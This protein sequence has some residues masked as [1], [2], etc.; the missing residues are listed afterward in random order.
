MRAMRWGIAP[1]GAPY[2]PAFPYVAYSGLTRRD[3]ADMWSYLSAL[4]GVERPNRPHE[5]AFPFG[6]RPL[7]MGWQFLFFAPRHWRAEAGRS[8]R[9]NRGAYL[10]RHL[11]HCAECHTG[12]NPLGALASGMDYAG[13]KG[14]ADEGTVPN[15]TPHETGIAGWSESDIVWLLKTG[16]TPEG[17]DVQ[18]SMAALVRHGSSHLGDDDLGAVAEYVLSLPPIDN[19]VRGEPAETAAQGADED[20][21]YDFQ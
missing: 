16:F 17:D 13:H 6:F 7:V 3:L 11:L 15:I 12:R 8:E 10:S 2:Y 20:Y 18:G 4:E 9:W 21:D 1:N 19:R 14:I 5:L